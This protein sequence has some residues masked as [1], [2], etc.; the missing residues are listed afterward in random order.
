MV[1]TCQLLYSDT[2][3][4]DKKCAAGAMSAC[5]MGILDQQHV[6]AVHAFTPSYTYPVAT[7]KTGFR[8]IRR[9]TVTW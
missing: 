6:L 9:C 7:L 4:T 3:V 1:V 2:S 5:A 8:L